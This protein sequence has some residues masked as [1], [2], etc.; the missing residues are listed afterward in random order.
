MKQFLLQFILSNS[1]LI[2][3]FISCQ[4]SSTEWTDVGSKIKYD[5]S[6]LKRP[7]KY[8]TNFHLITSFK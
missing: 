5:F 3:N 2:F 1:I 4:S 6:S 7:I 8:I